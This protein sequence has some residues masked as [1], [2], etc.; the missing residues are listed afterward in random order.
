[1]INRQLR[2]YTVH[3]EFMKPDTNTKM[4]QDFVIL[5]EDK[6]SALG[7]A[8]QRLPR[9]AA[10]HHEYDPSDP[11]SF[12]IEDIGRPYGPM[13]CYKSDVISSEPEPIS[14]QTTQPVIVPEQK[15]QN[16][17]NKQAI[18][19][20][21]IRILWGKLSV[22]LAETEDEDP[23]VVQ[24]QYTAE[25]MNSAVVI[26]DF[27]DFTD[28]IASA[29][30]DMIPQPPLTEFIYNFLAAEFPAPE[31]A[32]AS[33]SSDTSSDHILFGDILNADKIEDAIRQ[34]HPDQYKS[35]T[36]L[37]NQIKKKI[38]FLK[39]RQINIDLHNQSIARPS[40]IKEINRIVSDKQKHDEA[41]AAAVLLRKQQIDAE[42]T[43]T[44][45]PADDVDATP[46]D[47]ASE[48]SVE[49]D[50][51]SSTQNNNVSSVK[52][53][54]PDATDVTTPTETDTSDTQ[55]QATDDIPAN[56][57]DEP[58]INT[59]SDDY[60]EEDD[61]MED[62]LYQQADFDDEPSYDIPDDEIPDE[63]ILPPDEQSD[64]E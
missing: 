25:Q 11:V 15:R 51:H 55:K 60:D 62:D 61:D 53:K 48:N 64:D 12:R 37:D 23:L 39:S 16:N 50:M 6:L 45:Q 4:H 44:E 1:M 49:T 10:Q 41:E 57:P 58:D 32:I 33:E 20:T 19:R 28:R 22:L 21:Q 18:L 14:T 24:K 13:T 63:D 34:Q 2:L 54:T 40:E 47:P 5:A 42:S 26:S 3:A 36:E 52:T 17:P 43:L 27:D 38:S 7:M 9:Y 56:R 59:P 30:A 31:D 46:A 8:Y 29:Y 35:K